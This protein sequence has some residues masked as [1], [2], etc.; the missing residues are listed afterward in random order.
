MN[1]NEILRPEV[2][3]VIMAGVGA[4]GVSLIAEHAGAG[5]ML[6]MGPVLHRVPHAWILTTAL[7][8]S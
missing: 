6:R 5:E 8:E 4:S 2:G 3:W 7:W 1:L